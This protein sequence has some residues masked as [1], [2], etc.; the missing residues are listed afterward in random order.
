MCRRVGCTFAVI[1]IA[2]LLLLQAYFGAMRSA[3]THGQRDNAL[4]RAQPSR[5]IRDIVQ[6]LIQRP[7][8]DL[9]H[10]PAVPL[11]HQAGHRETVRNFPTQHE[12]GDH[13]AIG[14]QSSARYIHLLL[15]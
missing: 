14:S 7:A 3:N 4:D 12:V 2:T 8:I 6:Q 5:S 9:A 1:L 10:E 13:V 11:E 15:K